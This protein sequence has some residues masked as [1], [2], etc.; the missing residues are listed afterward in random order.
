[1]ASTEGL[2]KRKSARFCLFAPYA[3]SIAMVLLNIGS[4]EYRTG[5][6]SNYSMGVSVYACFIMVGLSII[7]TFVVFFR[8]W[9]YI[10]SHK[11]ASIFTY[12]LVML[13]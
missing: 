12:L 7:F 10:E 6:L 9:N 8:R 2:P 1:M 13:L 11:R 3:A 4:L 5:R